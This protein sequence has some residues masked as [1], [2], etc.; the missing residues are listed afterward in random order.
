MSLLT[1]AL[2]EG[3]Y[4]QNLFRMGDY[5]EGLNRG[6]AVRVAAKVMIEHRTLGGQM[7]VIISAEGS[8]NDPQE[9]AKLAY[10]ACAEKVPF[11]QM[12]HDDHMRYTAMLQQRKEPSRPQ[13]KVEELTLDD[14]DI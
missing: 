12:E 1:I 2:P 3:F 9:A 13:Q 8:A 4:V 6:Y 11:A 7:E 5:F 14:L 10:E